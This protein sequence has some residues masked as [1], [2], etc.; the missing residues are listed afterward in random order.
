MDTRRG[1]ATPPIAAH[2]GSI[3][4]QHANALGFQ[5]RVCTVFRRLWKDGGEVPPCYVVRLR[6]F[7]HVR[8]LRPAQSP[9]TPQIRQHSALRTRR[10]A[11][12]ALDRE[13]A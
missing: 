10:F 1:D 11:G 5:N 2:I 12:D 8:K 3:A 9:P 6:S 13:E 4:T 7:T